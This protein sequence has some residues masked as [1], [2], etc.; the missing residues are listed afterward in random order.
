MKKLTAFERETILAEARE[1][2]TCARLMVSDLENNYFI[3]TDAP[4]RGYRDASVRLRILSRCLAPLETALET[5][6][7][8]N[9]AE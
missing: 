1:D 3:W 2:L 4:H 7:N 8:Q 9:G 5:L 6:L